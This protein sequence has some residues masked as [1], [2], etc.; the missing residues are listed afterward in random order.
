MSRMEIGVKCGCMVQSIE[1][2]TKDTLYLDSS[3]IHMRKNYGRVVL[4]CQRIIK[5]TFQHL[6]VML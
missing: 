3:S 6:S 4:L 5:N 1:L 2:V